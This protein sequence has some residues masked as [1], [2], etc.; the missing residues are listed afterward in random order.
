MAHVLPSSAGD[1][2]GCIC[3]PEVQFLM[4][5]SGKIAMSSKLH[6]FDFIVSVL[7]RST[8]FSPLSHINARYPSSHFDLAKLASLRSMFVTVTLRHGQPISLY[9]I[10][11]FRARKGDGTHGWPS[12]RHADILNFINSVEGARD[13]L[14]SVWRTCIAEFEAHLLA[15]LQTDTVVV[16]GRSVPSYLGLNANNRAAKLHTRNKA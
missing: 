14:P 9:Y 10:W 1:A 2:R 11:V 4:E 3:G 16:S 15:C 5:P 6:Y 12:D 8:T 13:N 7:N